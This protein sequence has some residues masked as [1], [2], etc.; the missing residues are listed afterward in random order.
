[1]AKGAKGGRWEGVSWEGEGRGK[2][3]GEEAM[4]NVTFF[5]RSNTPVKPNKATQALEIPHTF[6]VI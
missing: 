6:S 4:Q 1:M 3:G 5:K 2:V